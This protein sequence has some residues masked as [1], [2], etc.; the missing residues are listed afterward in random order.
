MQ[1]CTKNAFHSKTGRQ[2]VNLTKWCNI[3]SVIQAGLLEVGVMK[4][5]GGDVQERAFWVEAA[6]AQAGRQEV[7]SGDTAV[8]RLHKLWPGSTSGWMT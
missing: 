7:A 1:A 5:A 6:V 8:F 4:Q 3:G 2:S